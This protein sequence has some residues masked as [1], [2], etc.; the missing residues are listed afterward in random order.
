MRCLVRA[1]DEMASGANVCRGFGSARL[2]CWPLL[3]ALSAGCRCS[4][5]QPAAVSSTAAAEVFSCQ[6]G[7][8]Q[9]TLSPGGV[10]P[11]LAEPG[12]DLGI[13]LPFSAESGVALGVG[14]TFF[15]TAL[16][17][18]A[19]GAVALLG[20]LGVDDATVELLELAQ[21]QGNVAPPRLAVDGE[22]VIVALQQGAPGGHDVRVA[23]LRAGAWSA[24]PEWR[25][26]AHQAS[27]ESNAFDLAAQAGQALIVW[28]D[29]VT[30]ANHG[31]VVAASVSL[32]LAPTA[33][34]EAIAISAPGVDAEA[35]RVAA[36]PGGY[37]LGWLVNP[38]SGTGPR[39]VYD[40]GG[41]ESDDVAEAPA[42]ARWI[43]VVALDVAGHVQGRP[44]RL[45]PIEQRVVG[46]DLIRAGD[47]SAWVAWRQ[48]APSPS[49]A[50]GRVF[51]AKLGPD[52]TEEVAPVR[53]DDVG[54]GE[55]TFL[56]AGATASPWLTFPDAQDRTLLMRVDR[57]VS[58]PLQLGPDI[59][60]AAALAAIGEHIL[61]AQPRGRSIELFAASCRADAPNARGAGDAGAAPVNKLD[62]VPLDATAPQPRQGEPQQKP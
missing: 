10:E 47:G 4:A 8:A 50:G 7:S 43:E 48:D 32:E 15:A 16:R 55:P 51:M 2:R 56:P 25:D 39:R 34:V 33:K 11:A 30:A 9:L 31:R 13:E 40:P 17:H 45:T 18:E 5:E 12:D 19:R 37:W 23:R 62:A 42:G 22:D 28:D 3:C 53:E 54:A 29:W 49:S 24:P 60:G 61:F 46:Y 14:S 59:A 26:V 57:V 44:R 41:R 21:V 27:D 35:P 6:R 1:W 38:H 20:R 36:R 58:R 52:G